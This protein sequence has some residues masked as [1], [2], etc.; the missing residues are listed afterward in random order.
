MESTVPAVKS[1]ILEKFLPGESADQLT[2]STE[3]IHSGILDSLARL[4]LVTFL[5]QQ[6]GIE[7]QAH[8]TD[9]ANFGTLED[10][11]RLVQSKRAGG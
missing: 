6:F 9:G 10:I 5:E 11:D 8:D 7:L 4:E 3:L 1:F 2:P